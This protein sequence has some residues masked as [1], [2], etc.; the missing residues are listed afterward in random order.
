MTSS[1]L[2]LSILFHH[3]MWVYDY[4][5]FTLRS[6]Y[7]IHAIWHHP[8]NVTCDH[9]TDMWQFITVWHHTNPNPKFSKWKIKEMKIEMK[10]KK[11]NS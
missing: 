5:V 3:I 8:S 7:V 9:V 1:S 11:K 6:I 10:K 4:D 2:E